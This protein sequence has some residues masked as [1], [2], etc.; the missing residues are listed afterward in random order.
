MK[1]SARCGAELAYNTTIGE[2]LGVFGSALVVRRSHTEHHLGAF[3][4][5]KRSK[6]DQD[7][8]RLQDKVMA[9]GDLTRPRMQTA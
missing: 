9:R 8:D 2:P 4:L 1:S 7:A 6:P 3:S 5:Q